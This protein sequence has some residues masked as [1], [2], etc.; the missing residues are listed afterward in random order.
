MP[1]LYRNLL[2]G[3]NG[4]STEHGE[5]GLHKVH[6]STSKDK[7]KG[8]NTCSETVGATVNSLSNEENSDV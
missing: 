1:I 8:V 6:Q 7:E 2:F 3:P 4:S 5:S